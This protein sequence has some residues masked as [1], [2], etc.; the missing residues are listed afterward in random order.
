MTSNVG[1]RTFLNVTKKGSSS[2]A[3][4]EPFSALTAGE[5]ARTM[6]VGSNEVEIT[7]D[8]SKTGLSTS[9]VYYTLPEE[10]FGA[11]V[12]TTTFTNSGDDTLTIQ[13][14]D[15]LAKMEP[16]GGLLD[17]QMKNM[18]RTLEGWMDVYQGSKD[19]GDITMP[20]YKLSTQPSDT[21]SVKVQIEGHYCLSMIDGGK[22]RK[23]GEQIPTVAS[24][25][26]RPLASLSLIAGTLDPPSHHLRHRQDLRTGEK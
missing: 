5:N 24:T 8:D 10:D 9:V 21:A 18:G 19:E 14:L 13:G 11:L 20:F 1:F 23:V 26:A 7:E 16:A 17:G 2:S 22:V 3:L 6:Y 25:N 12:R 15:G 4:I